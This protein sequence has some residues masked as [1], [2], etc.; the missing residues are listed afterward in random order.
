MFIYKYCP[1]CQKRNHKTHA[2]C[3]RCGDQLLNDPKFG[4]NVFAI[5][6]SL[7]LLLSSA[8][9]FASK[10]YF[11]Q[12]SE[13]NKKNSQVQNVESKQEEVK[14]EVIQEPA[15]EEVKSEPAVKTPAKKETVVA[16]QVT[17]A[18]AIVPVCDELQKQIF[19]K[20]FEVG[21]NEAKA[22]MSRLTDEVF[23]KKDYDTQEAELDR[24]VK[25]FMAKT[26]LLY[27]QYLQDMKSINCP[28]E[29]LLELKK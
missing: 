2:H 19:T 18:P 13:N 26:D 29:Q 27:L 16:P 20:K 5:T 25:D 6:L 1:K 8:T 14:P 15:K 17:P 11:N 21:F 28:A 4:K 9:V 12:R 10:A 22:E 24:I 23:A 7:V 3:V